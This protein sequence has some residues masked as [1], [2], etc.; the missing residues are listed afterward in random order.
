MPEENITPKRLLVFTSTFP[1]WK[2]DSVPADFVYCLAKEMTQHFSTF[3][4]AP[5]DSTAKTEESM[6]SITVFRFPYFLPR[7]QEILANGK[8]MLAN[9]RQSLLGK[10]QVPFLIVA[11]IFAFAKCVRNNK[12]DVVN[13]HWLVPQGLIAALF[14]RRY[15]FVHLTTIHA[16]DLFLLRRIP[17]GKKI[18][19]FIVD[20]TDVNIPVSQYNCDLLK[21]LTGRDFKSMVLPMGVDVDFF[22]GPPPAGLK[23]KLHI[24]PGKKT[25]LF[26]GKLSEKK[27]TVYLIRAMK[28]LLQKHKDIQLIIVGN[29]YLMSQCEEE[30]RKLGLDSIVKFMGFKPKTEI[31]NFLKAADVLVVPSI[32]DRH[33][34]TE[35]VPLVVLEGM[36]AGL[37][38]IASDVGGIS[39]V[40][41]HEQNGYIVR[42]K[43]VSGIAS[44]LISLFS[45]H[46]DVSMGEHSLQVIRSLDWKIIGEKYKAEIYECL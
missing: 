24:D 10:I 43:D 29:G 39:Q 35:G 11:E 28:E 41:H 27:G 26:I 32:V 1:R 14:K 2:D 45:D 8:G 30:T 13:S 36:A 46:R 17:F 42:E 9:I 31:K 6:D 3:V 20:R 7:K 21:Q 18:A 34:E 4:L 33:G 16:A 37:P 23:E 40:V 44:A 38:I 25:V 22:S 12:I 5:H 15:K 19:Q